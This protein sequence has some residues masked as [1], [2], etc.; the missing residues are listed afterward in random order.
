MPEVAYDQVQDIVA[1]RT[2]IPAVPT[3]M[4]H[5]DSQTLGNTSPIQYTPKPPDL[6]ERVSEDIQK[7]FIE[8]QHSIGA[9]LTW[10]GDNLKDNTPWGALGDRVTRA[11]I[12]MKERAE[13]TLAKKFS[14][15]TPNVLDNL[16]GAAPSLAAFLGTMAVAGPTLATG[17][18]VGAA[19]L[20]I[21]AEE[22]SKFKAQGKTTNESNALAAAIGIPT[23]GVMA[24]GFGVASKLTAPWL[25]K[26]L[27]DSIAKIATPAV[28]GA[29][30]F[31]AQATTQGSLELATGA[32]PY[33]GKDSLINLM[34]QTANNAVLG[35]ILGGATALPYVFK[36]HAAIIDGFQKL[37]LSPKDAKTNADA[38]LGQASHVVMDKIDQHI[39]IS[40]G[41]QGRIKPAPRLDK[42]QIQPNVLDRKGIPQD[43]FFPSVGDEALPAKTVA[44][45][46]AA[47]K[48]VKLE[49]VDVQVKADDKATTT[50]T[51]AKYMG[52]LDK[53]IARGTYLSEDMKTMAPLEQDAAFWAAH[54][55]EEML[56]KVIKDPKAVAIEKQREIYNKADIKEPFKIDQ[57]ELERSVMEY[58]RLKPVFEQALTL[59]DGAKSAISESQLY[60]QEAGQVSK[61]LGTIDEIREN[62]ISNRL[63]KPEPPQDFVKTAGKGG[64]KQFSAHS[65]ERFY[66]DPLMA[67]AGGKRF[68]TT[69][70]ADLVTIHN[71]EMAA[72]NHSRQLAD[73][74]SDMK[75][76][77][78]ASWVEEGA[79]PKGWQK[80]GKVSKS[81]SMEEGSPFKKRLVLAAPKGI[82]EGLK[83]L[84]D[85]DFFRQHIP[86]IAKI[87]KVQGVIKTGILSYSFFHDMTFATQTLASIDGPR[88]LAEMPS[89]LK[90]RLMQQ[91][92]FRVLEQDALEHNLST[93]A[94]REVQDI[95][96]K[97]EV[98]EDAFSKILNASAAK[99]LN[100]ISDA[101][102]KFL[103]GEY[104]RWIKVQTYA[105]NVAAWEARNPNA[106]PEQTREAKLGFAKATNAEFGGLNWEALGVN[107]TTQSILRTFLLAPD[108]VVSMGLA[109][110]YAVGRGT[111]GQQAR[112]TLFKAV[113]GG[114]AITDGL[115]YLMTGHHLWDNKQ[116][117]KT[118]IEVAPNV[119]VS[120]V[121]GAPGELMK[122]MSNTIESGSLKGVQR[123]AEGKASPFLASGITAISGINYY[124]ADIW[125]GDSAVEKTVNGLWNIVSHDI[126]APIGITGGVSYA[127]RE[128]AQTPVGWGLTVTG[129][130]RFSK[131]SETM[132][133]T[134]MRDNVIHA[135]RNGDTDY[136]KGLIAKGDLSSDE[137]ERLRERS[138]KSDVEIK[139][140]HMKLEKV[141][142]LYKKN[143]S[144]DLKQILAEKFDRFLGSS[145]LPNEKKRIQKLYNALDK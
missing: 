41:E 21:G 121:R 106:T 62:Y 91:P 60:Y 11:G 95:L 144:S 96:T 39:D 37:G 131:P 122:L 92:G 45:M 58:T 130:G 64:L 83:A 128:D 133:K 40:A 136:V 66:D 71:S 118:E 142:D 2:T 105:K 54:Y 3:T 120:L 63:Y 14:N 88:T 104:Q 125:K 9:G 50:D 38:L 15:F 46:S 113:A 70:L 101:H 123:Y 129:S 6:G 44:E 94:T 35:G 23:A 116:G 19:G 52:S 89:V 141:I 31:G 22:F 69:N 1:G 124:G 13:D 67:L 53:Q 73:A 36:Q 75:P 30:V 29:S 135:Y 74:L 115:N 97:T 98:K 82:A 100:A 68:A 139:T 34:A 49:P 78:L 72:V 140:E 143:P 84:V 59:S 127:Q 108:W 27:G 12:V 103:F 5:D 126:P 109:T 80:V 24:A 114:L 117:H 99:Q 55:D 112:G 56:N 20:S 85:P 25:T 145:A 47:N 16:V 93:A 86:G 33:E 57:E 26:V 111:A 28:T 119:Y 48:Y 42:G 51:R 65:L 77:P 43:E 61:A 8:T 90:N 138:L 134:Q 4:S 87:Q 102:T 81:V 107:K 137:A 18:V 7:P 17:A 32:T 76:T 110:K 10:L 132:Q 79:L